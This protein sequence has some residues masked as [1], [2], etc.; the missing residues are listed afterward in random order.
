MAV[1]TTE[2]NCL[3][4]NSHMPNITPTVLVRLPSAEATPIERMSFW[5]SAFA[6][7]A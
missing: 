1:P 3:P 7:A 4:K 5:G 6:I 2:E